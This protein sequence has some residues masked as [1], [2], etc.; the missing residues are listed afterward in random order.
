MTKKKITSK[1]AKEVS[2]INA[3]ISNAINLNLN[4]NDIVELMIEESK[5][6]ICIEYENSLKKLKEMKL[7]QVLDLAAELSLIVLAD[8]STGLIKAILKEFSETKFS[9]NYIVTSD[10]LNAYD[11]INHKKQL[12]N[13]DLPNRIIRVSGS[14]N[15]AIPSSTASCVEGYINFWKK[16]DSTSSINILIK[17]SEKT[18]KK[19]N[20]EMNKRNEEYLKE[21][22]YLKKLDNNLRK[23]TNKGKMKAQF[24]KNILEK[25]PEGKAV[26]ANVAMIVNSQKLLS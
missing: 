12:D 26:L 19:I 3:E 16:G 20:D 25:T 13:N 2:V 9:T 15:I 10:Y 23:I 22:A 17:L 1:P 14:Q 8:Q 11:F 7:F 18:I 21:F 24:I 5:E 4:S 6:A